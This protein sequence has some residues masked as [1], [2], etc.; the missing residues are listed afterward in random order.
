[1]PKQRKNKIKPKKQK[2]AMS[3]AGYR[4]LVMKFMLGFNKWTFR[5]DGLT[6]NEKG[7]FFYLIK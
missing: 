5:T 3:L 1:M 7:I 2:C 6:R 4:T